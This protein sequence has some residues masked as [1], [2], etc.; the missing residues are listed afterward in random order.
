MNPEIILALQLLL[1]HVITDFVLQSEKLIIQKEE[2]KAKAPFLYIHAAVSGL[3]TYVIIQ[4]W[5]M[6]GVAIFIAVTHFFIDLWK[7]YKKS[8]SLKIFLLELNQ[9]E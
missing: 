2:K 1:A 8:D 3:L 9:K 5:N 6:W 7:L 4:D